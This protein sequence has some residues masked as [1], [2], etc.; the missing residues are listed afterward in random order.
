MNKTGFTQY[1]AG[2]KV[3][4]EKAMLPTTRFGGHIV[5]GHLDG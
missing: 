1:Q 4:L 5:S 2:D 3:N